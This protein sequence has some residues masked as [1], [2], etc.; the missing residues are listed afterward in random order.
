MKSIVLTIAVLFSAIGFGRSQAFVQL[1]SGPGYGEQAY[2]DLTTDAVTNVPNESW[3]LIFTAFGLQD[4]GIHVNESARSTFGAPAPTVELYLADTSVFEAVTAFDTTFTRLYNDEAGWA[5]GAGNEARNPQNP[6]DFGWGVYS[7]VSN[8]VTGNRVFVILL[9]SGEYKKFIV[10]SLL[11]ST[12]TIRYSDLN[13][14]NERTAQIDKTNFSDTG[15]AFFSFETGETIDLQMEDDFHLSFLRYV[16]PLDDGEGNILDYNVTGV[17]TGPGVEVAKFAGIDPAKVALE[18]TPDTF[19]TR[20]D[21]IGYDW[22]RFDFQA[23]WIIEDSL[24]YVVKTPGNQLYKM[25]FVDFEGSSTGVATFEKTDL[26]MLTNTREANSTLEGINVFPNPA[27]TQITVTYAL[28]QGR[29]QVQISLFNTQGQ[30]LFSVAADGFEGLN[31]A[32]IQLPAN[33]TPGMYALQI[34]GSD[35]STSQPLI[36]K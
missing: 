18:S 13:G 30:R 5:F 33:L 16:T 3:D 31:T 15:L 34:A 25:V 17:I 6:F 11:L 12:Y 29:Q 4:A 19:S 26:G 7:P 9:R 35:F 28:R 14:E 21:V 23:G 20:L 8:Q 1:S 32:D 22:K 24:S 2:Y 36:I 10:E 27:A